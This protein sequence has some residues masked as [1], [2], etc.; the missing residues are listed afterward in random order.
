MSVKPFLTDR[1]RLFG[2][3]PCPMY[4]V[5]M[6]VAAGFGWFRQGIIV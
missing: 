3:V 5:V 6:C 1:T 2:V 4:G